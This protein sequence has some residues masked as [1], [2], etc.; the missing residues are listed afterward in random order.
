LQIKPNAATGR[1][2]VSFRLQDVLGLARKRWVLVVER[3][4]R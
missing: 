1:V 2:E 4:L 3:W